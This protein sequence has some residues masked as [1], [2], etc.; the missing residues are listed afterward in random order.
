MTQPQVQATVA[1]VSVMRTSRSG[2]ERDRN[3]KITQRETT[4]F[5]SLTLMAI[6]KVKGK[7]VPVLN[8]LSTTP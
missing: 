2:R 4:C 1:L 5:I 8:Q 3:G 6:L 7:T